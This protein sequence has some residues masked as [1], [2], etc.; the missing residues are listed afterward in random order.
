MLAMSEQTVQH[1]KHVVDGFS[2]GV[3]LG[4]VTGVLG[5]FATLVTLL[6]LGMQIVMNWQKFK[7]AILGMKNKDRRKED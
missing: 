2:V 7:D 1:V 4:W 6:W 3:L 5:P